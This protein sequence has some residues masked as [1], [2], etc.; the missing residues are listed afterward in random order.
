MNRK[1]IFFDIDGTLVSHV[2][3]RHIPAPTIQA[4]KELAGNGHVTAIATGRNLALTQKTAAFFNIDL[5]VCCN[6]AHVTRLAP[7]HEIYSTWLDDGFINS[8]RKKVPS[9]SKQAY[10]LDDQH[11][12]TDWGRDF[13]DI[14]VAE[15][16]GAGCKKKLAVLERAQLAYIFS[17]PPRE[18]LAYGNIDAI[19]TSDYTEFRPRGV[20]K[21]NGIVRAA[22]DCG[23]AP[24]DV[25]T[26]GDGLNDIEMVKNASIG[27]AV[28]GANESLK[29]VADLVADD[30][31]DGGV[32]SV[33]RFLGMAKEAYVSM[34]NG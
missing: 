2:G 1:L 34:N 30:I 21:W 19:E 32:L 22:A 27:I 15:E 29:A 11:V 20:S 33:F 3:K 16:A 17:T 5:V 7:S 8:F 13:F 18:W 25:V 26:V 24:E 31:D 9:I 12:Y 10:A 28:G 23:F 14:L 6:G 4:V